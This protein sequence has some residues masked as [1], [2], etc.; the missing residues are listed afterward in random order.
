MRSRAWGTLLFIGALVCALFFLRDGERRGAVPVAPLE[1]EASQEREQAPLVAPVEERVTTDRAMAETPARSDSL[2]RRASVGLEVALRVVDASGA[3]IA[4]AQVV[5]FEE[6][7]PTWTARPQVATDDAGVARFERR[8]AGPYH[9][10]VRHAGHAATRI[11]P[12]TTLGAHEFVLQREASLLVRLVDDADSSPIDGVEL[13]L[14][15]Q[16]PLELVHGEAALETTKA[17]ECTFESLL[18]GSYSLQASTPARWRPLAVNLWIGPG[19]QEQV[20]RA[21]RGVVARGLVVDEDGDPVS[22]ARIVVA[23]RDSRHPTTDGAGRFELALDGPGELLRIEHHDHPT[24]ELQAPPLAFAPLEPGAAP[25]WRIALES[26]S[27]ATFRVVDASGRSRQGARAMIHERG[28]TRGR[29]AHVDSSGMLFAYR[30]RRG[31]EHLVVVRAPGCATLVR[32]FESPRVPERHLGDLVLDTRPARLTILVRSREGAPLA[33]AR[34]EVQEAAPLEV[35]GLEEWRRSALTNHDGLVVFEDLPAGGTIAEAWPMRSHAPYSAKF[36]LAAGED[37]RIELE[38]RHAGRMRGFVVGADGSPVAQAEVVVVPAEERVDWPRASA[39]TTS[40]G[41]WGVD[42]LFESGDHLLHVEP[43]TPS[44]GA[45]KA[46]RGGVFGPMRPGAETI[47]IE[48][49]ELPWR[50]LRLLDARGQPQARA[51]L[52]ASPPPDADGRDPAVP[53]RVTLA[54]DDKGEVQV[55]WPSDIALHIAWRAANG[56][57]QQQVV[58]W[59]QAAEIVILRPR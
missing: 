16:A 44:V 29:E 48:L 17:G 4:G 54:C 59:T 41:T 15:P 55:A 22:D 13:R 11:G 47:R 42:G 50:R 52:V 24:L 26:A 30:L 36:E 43:P 51:A 23:P 46:W 35:L 8:G 2:A 12:L 39:S 34:V 1:A 58:D 5:L 6:P 45:R 20:L 38:A 40:D 56:A 3:P 27:S 7:F 14:V 57:E 19:R 37:R 53:R 32:P 25:R 49:E 21:R 28:A 18:P 10:A 9:Y 33:D 31:V